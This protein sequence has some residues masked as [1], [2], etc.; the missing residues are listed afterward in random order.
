MRDRLFATSVLAGLAFSG[1]AFAQAPVQTTQPAAAAEE[2]EDAIVVTGSRIVRQ[3][4]TAISPVTTVGAQDI[5]LTATLSVEQLLNELPS[6]IPGNTVTSNNAGG[7]DFATLDLRGLGP[8]RTLILVNGERVPASSTTGVVDLNTIP[9][10]LLDRIEVVTGGASAVY[11]SDA[12]AGVVNFILKDDYEGAEVRGTVGAAQDGNAQE[13]SM[14]FLWGG[15][16]D[17]GKGNLTAFANYYNREGVLQ[18]AYDFSAVSA[19]LIC[20]PAD[21]NC[22]SFSVVDSTAEWVAGINAGSLGTAASGGSATP[23]WGQIT[24]GAGGAFAGL[25]TNPATAAGFNGVD[26]DCNPATPGVA[27]NSGTLSFGPT[28]VLVPYRSG[29][30]CAVPSRTNANGESSRFNFA[31]DNNM[32]IPAERFGFSAIGNYEINDKMSMDMIVTYANSQAQVQLAPT[33]ITGLSIPVTSPLIP[34]SLAAALATRPN[35]TANFTM[36]WRSSQVGPRVGTFSNDAFNARLG[37]TGDLPAGWEWR[38]NLGYGKSTFTGELQ[39]NVNRTALNQGLTGCAN[40]P[41]ISRLPNC[42]NVS[43]FGPTALTPAMINFLRVDTKEQGNYEQSSVA[44]YVRG[45]LFELPAGPV[46]AVFGA[47]YRDDQ[48]GFKVDD[49]QRTG[50]IYGFNATQSVNGARDVY[51]AYGEVAVPILSEQPFAHYLGFEA[52]YRYSDYS[53]IGGVN[54]FKLGAEYAPVSWFKFRTVYNEAIRAPSLLET[55]QNGDQGF[56]GYTDPCNDPPGAATISATIQARC[57]ATGVPAAVLPTFAQNNSQVQAF[58]FGNP[59]LLQETGETFT[60]GV[61]FEPDWLPIGD[62]KTSIDYYDVILRDP[63]V[64]RGA[65]TIINSCYQANIAADCAQITRNAVSGQI[66]AINT[67]LTN[68]GKL[69]TK[70]IDVQTEFGMDLDEVFAG[71]PGRIR[72]N[73]LYSYLDNYSI[74]FSDNDFRGTTDAGIGGALFP[75]RSVLTV[76]YDVGDWAFQ[77]R[78]SYTPEMESIT[79][80]SDPRNN[81]PVANYTDLSVRYDVTDSFRIVA[82][83]DNLF[84]EK[85]PQTVDGVFSQ[86]NTDPQIYRLLGRGLSISGRLKF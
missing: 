21:P 62:L 42:Q 27:V 72:F 43:I 53:T 83:V 76:N 63:I 5:E 45:D 80:G 17:G 48:G 6:V 59:N 81:S 75:W 52:G 66:D 12:I 9:A 56:P 24:G 39:N 40:I 16:F 46:S 30:A 23:P 37:F 19:A 10:G 28:G 82:V 65:Q 79:G 35:P 36:A 54:S 86:S 70:G 68:L 77:L 55:F 69:M 85:P 8:Q 67:S 2:D 60:F 3:D 38:L 15:N 44:G 58:A 31:P 49:A 18:S 61:V 13:T 22:D 1:A 57:L 41:A 4:F 71:A 84:D 50:N 11:G 34:A 47:E 20:N 51:E 33:P 7:E 25:S 64:A 78:N 32:I 73:F 74:N 14:E 26:T 29:G